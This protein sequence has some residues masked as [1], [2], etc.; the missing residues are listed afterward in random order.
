MTLGTQTSEYLTYKLNKLLPSSPIS[1]RGYRLYKL[2]WYCKCEGISSN[3]V[4]KSI[5]LAG[6]YSR[7][8]NPSIIEIVT[9]TVA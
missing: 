3:T 9:K 1:V 6:V 5:S 7:S 8:L 2:K 4:H